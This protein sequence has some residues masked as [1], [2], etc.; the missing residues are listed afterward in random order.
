MNCI[1][2]MKKLRH[3]EVRL[4]I[5]NHTAYRAWSSSPLPWA[6]TEV[7]SVV[8]KGC[9]STFT[10]GSHLPGRARGPGQGGGGA[11]LPPL[12]RVCLSCL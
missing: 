12:P 11:V 10:S 6:M 5:Q 8:T 2:R 3:R 9:C 1:L 7:A 4:L